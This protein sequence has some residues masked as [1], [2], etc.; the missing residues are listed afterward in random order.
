M[1]AMGEDGQAPTSSFSFET[2]IKK[3]E[4]YVKLEAS[5]KETLS[6]MAKLVKYTAKNSSCFLCK[7]DTTGE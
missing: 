3:V 5:S 6:T 7:Q 2:A 4:E 1:K